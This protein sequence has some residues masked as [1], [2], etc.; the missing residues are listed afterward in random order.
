MKQCEMIIIE[1]GETRQCKKQAVKDKK[2]C[3]DCLRGINRIS[4]SKPIQQGDNT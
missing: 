4:P 3:A 1:N 2:Y